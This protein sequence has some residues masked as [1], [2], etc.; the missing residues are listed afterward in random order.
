M[1]DKLKFA[2]VLAAV[3]VLIAGIIAVLAGLVWAD[4]KP[5]ERLLAAQVLDERVGGIVVFGF[6]LPFFLGFL[7]N[8][9]FRRYISAPSQLAEEIQLIVSANPDHRATPR[10][11]AEL[12]KVVRLVNELADSRQALQRD[13]EARI[14]EASRDLEAEKNRLAA[15]MSELA[16]S[17]VVC[18]IEGRILLYNARARQLLTQP[19]D[20]QSGAAT[21]SLVGLGR[22]I[23]G[24]LDRNLIT[25][26]LENV[27]DRLTRG[28]MAPVASF[29]TTTPAGQLIRVQMAPVV[30]AVEQGRPEDMAKAASAPEITGFV[31][32]LENI[33]RTIE[34]GSRRDALMQTLTE[35]TRASLANIR[36]AVEMMLSF[37]DMDREGHN[38]FIGII[39]EEAAKLSTALN[40]TVT[41]FA[42]SLK[43]QWPLEDMRGAD[44]I[45]AAQR[46][47]EQKLGLQTKTENVDESLWL[48]VDS[49]S[50]IQAFTYLASRLRD[51][52]GVREVRFGLESAGRLAH[53]DIVWTGAPI[54]TETT[55]SWQTEPMNL[56]GEASP[57]SLKDVIE[58]HDGELWYQIEKPRHREYF[59]LA[60]PVTHP[61]EVAWT[62]PVT[63]ESRPE[64]YDFDLFHQAGQNPELDQ[65]LLSELTYTVFDTETTG[66][67]PSEGDEIISIGAVRLVNGRLLEHEVFEQL[68]D[69]RRSLSA[70]SIKI[71]GIQPE[72]LAGQPAIDQVLP[73]FHRFC[74]D[75]VLIAHNAAFDMRFLQMKEGPTGIRFTQPVL[76]TL[77]LSAVI[78]PHLNQHKLEAI[79]E[80]LGINVIGRHTALGD[81]MVTGEVFLKMIPLLAGM[82]IR[83]LGEAREAAQKTFYARIEY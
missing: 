51:E 24:I 61:E 83:T 79:A 70:Q 56:G 6:F 32:I 4:L 45:A 78:H 47:I 48:K 37:P 21:R 31:L 14:R 66:L 19:V 18:N 69:P 2:A 63:G 75:T 12:R 46:R 43:T 7:I 36:A 15:L 60:V 3:Y 67:D 49:Y 65:R 58:R 30:S 33:T 17:V 72:M 8:H 29:V 26:A 76:D 74:E 13:V 1:R 64:Y 42:D 10:G 71:H 25:H 41:E 35:G 50:L 52:F 27:H 82:G 28:N 77:L 55:M 62:V 81:A 23:F 80:R 39:G 53:L 59:R 44:L 22:S 11:S 38:R 34:M 68:V 54:G 73:A 20:K 57:L 16:Q 40:R 9:L 5:E